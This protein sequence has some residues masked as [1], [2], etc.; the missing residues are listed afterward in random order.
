MP[1]A[2]APKAPCVDVWLSPHT[3]VLP[4]CVN[5]RSGPMTC[6][7]PLRLSPSGKSSTPNS[8][9]L[10]SSMS[11]LAFAWSSMTQ[12]AFGSVGVEWSIVAMVLSGRRT[13]RPRSRRPVKACGD[14][15][16]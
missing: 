13:F 3:M 16:S 11:E 6:T 8:L 14:V 1:N 15:T 4:G 2:S 7:I 10:V 9:Q 5:P 12:S